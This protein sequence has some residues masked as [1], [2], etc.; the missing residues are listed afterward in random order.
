MLLQRSLVSLGQPTQNPL[1]MFNHCASM[2]KSN[3]Q[4]T[5]YNY[6]K[7]NNN[8]LQ[9]LFYIVNYSQ[10]PSPQADFLRYQKQIPPL[11]NKGG[12][13]SYS[14]LTPTTCR[15]CAIGK[16]VLLN[17]SGTGNKCM[18]SLHK[19]QAKPPQTLFQI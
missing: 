2:A 4:I 11:I 10:L 3:V 13:I 12:T 18:G 5:K 19:L 14:Q 1:S 16:S 6:N 8:F 9:A 15:T 7:I 17:K